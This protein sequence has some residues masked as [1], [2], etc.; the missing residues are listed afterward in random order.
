MARFNR[1]LI[2]KLIAVVSLVTF[3]VTGAAYGINLSEENCLR[4]PMAFEKGS[5]EG[6]D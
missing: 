4:K 2:F 6:T 3:S 1:L 5:K